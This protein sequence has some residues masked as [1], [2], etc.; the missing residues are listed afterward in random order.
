MGQVVI[1]GGNECMECRYRK[2]CKEYGFRSKIYAKAAGGFQGKIGT[3]ELVIFFTGAVSH[4]MVQNAM[5]QIQT[6]RT[7]IVRSRSA[8]ACALRSILDEYRGKAV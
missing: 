4:K 5:G 1:I 6:D 3:P 8:G 2:I 7:Q